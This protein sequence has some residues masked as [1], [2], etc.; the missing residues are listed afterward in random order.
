[1]GNV[2][3]TAILCH[4]DPAVAIALTELSRREGI[5]KSVLIR[6]AVENLL[7]ARASRGNTK[8]LG[9]LAT[10]RARAVF[11]KM[12]RAEMKAAIMKEADTPIRKKE[13]K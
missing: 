8:M 7:R 3:R 9:E 2:N 4:L 13:S 5:P 11:Q 12:I 6:E 10:E 1:M